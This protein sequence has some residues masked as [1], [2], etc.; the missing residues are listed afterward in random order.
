M[1][2]IEQVER[3]ERILEMIK[4][5]AT[6]TPK[7]FAEKLMVSESML[8]ELM[9]VLKE[10]G[11]QIEYCSYKQSYVLAEPFEIV[12][13]PMIGACDSKKNTY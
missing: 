12:F 9:K 6:G 11:A 1:K 3:Y 2:F 8:Y 5:E 10:C 13:G 4:R 7:E